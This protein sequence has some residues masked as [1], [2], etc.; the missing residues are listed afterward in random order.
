MWTQDLPLEVDAAAPRGR[1]FRDLAA[2]LLRAASRL[3]DGLAARLD[4]VAHAP[5][6]DPVLE[7]YADAGAPEGAL[8]VD[9]QLVGHLTGVTRL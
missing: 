2:E 6:T 9:G 3:L 8:Y 5:D 1:R 4:W 7:F